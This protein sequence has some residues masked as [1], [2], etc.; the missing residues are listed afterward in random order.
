MVIYLT[1]FRIWR[2]F[3]RNIPRTAGCAYVATVALGVA[4]WIA[5]ERTGCA[6][7]GSIPRS[8]SPRPRP[9]PRRVLERRPLEAVA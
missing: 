4:I 8:G 6:S 7:S 9:T 3:D 2:L 1:H 5:A